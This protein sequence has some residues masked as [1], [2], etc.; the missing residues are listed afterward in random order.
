MMFAAFGLLLLLYLPG[1]AIFRA[2]VLER[3]R[4]SALAAEERLYWAVV[5]SLAWSSMVA[6]ALAAAHRYSIGRLL[7]ANA[8]LTGAIVAV[9]RGRLRLHG[10]PRPTISGLVPI[11]LIGLCAYLFY[12]PAE[13]II[14]GKDPG[15]YIN[16]GIQIGQRGA[17]ITRDALIAAVPAPFRGLFYPP[18]GNA[19]YYSVRFMGFFIVDPTAGTVVGQFPHLYPVWVAIGYG[20]GGLTGAL[21]VLGGLATLGVVGLYFLGARLLGR[22][23]A[24]AGAALLAMSVV[25]VWFA[26][27]PNA[28]MLMQAV[29][30]PGLLAFAR[31]H[32]DDD[33]FFEPVAAVLLGLLFFARVESVLVAGAAVGAALLLRCEGLR[34]RAAF[35]AP[36]TLFALL[37]FA[38]YVTVAAPYAQLPFLVV[39]HPTLLHVVV[40]G[41]AIVAVA[42]LYILSGI[43]FVAAAVRTWLPRVL[44]VAVAL[45]AAYAFFLRQAG[46]RLAIHD[47]NSLRTFTWYLHPA[48]LAAAVL[49]YVLVVWRRFWRDPAFLLLSAVSAF[50]VFYKIQIVPEHFWM[51]RRFVAVI[52]PSALLFAAAAIFTGFSR[53]M[54]RMGERRLLEAGS[55]VARVIIRLVV[56]ALLA[57]TLVQSTRAILPHVEYAGIVPRVEALAHRFGDTDLVV[58][59]S[60]NASDLHVLALPLAYIYARNVLVLANPKPDKALFAG[61][62]DWARTRYR[63]V[64]FVGSGGT[65]L[66]SRRYGVA[67]EGSDRFQVPEYESPRNAYPARSRQK[68]FDFGIYRFTPPEPAVSWFSLDVGTRDDLHVV[69]F[70]AKERN[71]ARTFRWTRDVSYVSILGIQPDASLLTIVMEN[72]G[73]PASV[74]PATVEVSLEGRTLG[75]ATVGADPMPYSFHVPRDLAVAVAGNND[76]ALLKLVSS[77]WNPRAALGVND[78]RDLGVMVDRIDLR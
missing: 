77:T 62:L 78:P 35:L 24:A 25:Q 56:L 8:A 27:Y 70:H 76:T 75:T 18:Y 30:L 2:P 55:R 50:F 1:A 61:F 45:G 22:T 44:A 34:L 6:L 40:F 59:E 57:S 49:G 9:Y 36:L 71:A 73:R 63:S 33:P 42:V 14:G 11:A 4:R 5:L 23:A 37:A 28:E 68:E 10:A 32:V 38:Y 74:A 7:V 19:T 3:D 47:A 52:M 66:L 46:G 12:P 41:G 43:P 65:D 67:V 51:A 69:R 48:G 64:Y 72:G 53:P 31:S 20:L 21:H 15:V 39:T 13:Y 60:R 26:R 58:V 17:L 16:E 54:L 29:V